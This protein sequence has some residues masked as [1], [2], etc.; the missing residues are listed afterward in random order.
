MK[1]GKLDPVHK[2][3]HVSLADH[4]TVAA[5][6]GPVPA[7]GWEF[8]VP[9]S[10]MDV[11]GND[12][13]GDCAEAAAL[14]MIQAQQFNVGKVC[15]PTR[16]DAFNLYTRVTGFNPDDPSTDNGTV[17]TDLLNYWQNTG[18][19][20]GDRVHKIVG[21]ASLDISSIAQLRW[22]AY[23]FG[24][25]MLGI[26]CP[27]QCEDNTAN[28]NFAP[29]LPIIG[30]HAIIQEGEGSAGGKLG[31]WGLWIPATWQFLLGYI[32]EAY[33]VVTPDWLNQQQKSPIG[34]DLNGLVAAMGAAQGAT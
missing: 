1:L 4:M 8:A 2:P 34:L 29:G 23:T 11:L 7:G 22:A 25:S 14:H 3:E 17:L 13:A 30:G 31:S 28:W 12:V 5:A 26:R 27:Q 32:D 10:A 33:I 18:I 24:G 19:T 20:L 16:S 9:Q 21:W 6:W 15:V